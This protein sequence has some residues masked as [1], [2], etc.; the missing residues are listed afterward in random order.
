MSDLILYENGICYK[1]CPVC[2]EKIFY[3]TY[4][5]AYASIVKGSKCMDCERKR[6]IGSGNP[7]FGKK[8]STEKKEAMKKRMSENNPF[9]NKHHTNETKKKMRDKKIGLPSHM[10][11]KKH[12]LISKVKMS[13]AAS[14]R[15]GVLNNRWRGGITP[16]IN[17][18]RSL[19][20]Y[21]KWEN[22]VIYRDNYTCQKTKIIYK[23]Y[24]LVVHHIHNFASIIKENNITTV[25]QAL[26][27]EQLWDINNGI[28]LSK[29]SHKEF[30]NKY[31]TRNNNNEQ[32]LSFLKNEL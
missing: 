3:K 4:E 21:K 6:R 27:C 16:L 17:K 11:G 5:R 10:T 14:K 7:M 13:I 18:I 8:L 12:T 31:W 20:Q 1:Y 32:L 26:Q 22:D 9:K 25:E 2:N 24:K 19:H 29:E 28:T 15:R 23:K 30:H